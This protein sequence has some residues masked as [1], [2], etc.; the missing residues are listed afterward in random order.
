MTKLS[1]TEI[2]IFTE[3]VARFEQLG[4]LEIILLCWMYHAYTYDHLSSLLKMVDHVFHVPVS[5]CRTISKTP[6]IASWTRMLDWDLDE[7]QTAREQSICAKS[8]SAT[9]NK[10]RQ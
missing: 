10:R 2:H 7:P 5:A 8:L 1:G 9:K 6:K 3:H 4:S